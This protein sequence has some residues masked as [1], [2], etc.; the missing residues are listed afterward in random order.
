MAR[1]ASIPVGTVLAALEGRRPAEAV[2]L[3]RA[4]AEA[5]VPT[6]T[7]PP[8]EY[9]LALP[10]LVPFAGE[11]PRG[12]LLEMDL[13]PCDRFCAKVTVKACLQRQAARWPGGNK[14]ADGS[15][16]E[17]GAGVHAY[18]ASGQ[19]EQGKDYRARCPW[20]PEDFWSKGRFRFFRP[21]VLKQR[22]AKARA[23]AADDDL[24]PR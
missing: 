19:C 5:S 3:I 13:V 10:V 2:R 8:D 1:S 24:A 9:Q 11:V 21:D 17:K 20:I 15:V 14:L 12:T 16:R 7:P 18:C 22:A 23:D 6:P 4:L